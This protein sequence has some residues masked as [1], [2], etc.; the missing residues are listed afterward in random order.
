V[1]NYWSVGSAENIVWAY[2]DPIPECPK[3]K[4]LLCFF[5]EKV[6]IYVDGE[7]QARPITPWS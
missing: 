2:P 5:N 7:R 4:D 6:D 1:A 3:I